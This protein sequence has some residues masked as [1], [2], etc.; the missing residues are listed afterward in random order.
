MTLLSLIVAIVVVGVALWVVNAMI[1]MDAKVK[2]ILN[3]VVI[4]VLLLWIASAFGVLGACG[5]LDRRI[6]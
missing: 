5:V 2:Q 6:R 4:I 1:P 3:V